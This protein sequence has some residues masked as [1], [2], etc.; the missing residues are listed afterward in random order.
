M[1]TR[2]VAASAALILCTML[3]SAACSSSSEN[4]PSTGSSSSPEQSQAEKNLPT[5]DPSECATTSDK[6]PEG[7]EVDLDVSDIEIATPATEPPE[8]NTTMSPS[9]N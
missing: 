1:R 8:T 2:T 4:K 9:T 3:G 5:G 7:C 6:L